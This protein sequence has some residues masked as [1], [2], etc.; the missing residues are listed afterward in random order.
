MLPHCSHV[1]SLVASCATS[2]VTSHVHCLIALRVCHLLASRIV[3]L[4]F[5]RYIAY[6]TIEISMHDEI[7]KKNVNV[8]TK[9]NRN[10]KNEKE[11]KM[12]INL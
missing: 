7:T 8:Q 10:P 12:K 9:T 6:E 11:E 2:N 4:P 5:P 1:A 3:F